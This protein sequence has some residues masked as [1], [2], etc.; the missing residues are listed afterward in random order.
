[1][2]GA[3]RRCALALGIGLAVPTV[4]HAQMSVEPDNGALSAPMGS[5][6]STTF[7]LQTDDPNR[8][9]NALEVTCDGAVVSCSSDPWVMIDA[10][11][12]VTV[13]VTYTVS[14]T[15]G[16][17]GTITVSMTDQF[18]SET[19]DGSAGVTVQSSTPHVSANPATQYTGENV[20]TN[21]PSFTLTNSGDTPATYTATVTCSG[22]S[23]CSVRAQPPS[24][25]APGA[26][27]GLIVDY[28]SY[29]ASAGNESITLH[30]TS[31]FAETASSTVTIVPLS[32]AVQVTSGTAPAAPPPTQSATYPFTIAAVGNNTSPISYTLTTSCTGAL[33]CGPAAPTSVS[34]SPGSPASATV[35]A[36]ATGNLAG[37]SGTAALTASYT[38]GW[39]HPY[40]STS[41][42]NVMVPDV[43]SYT[44]AVSPTSTTAYNE[45]NV[46]TSYSFT[47]TNSGNTQASYAVTLPT[48]SGTAS[49]CSFSSSSGG[50]TST[51]VSVNPN[52]GTASVPVYFTTLGAGQNASITLQAAG[53]SNTASGAVTVVPQSPAVTVSGGGTVSLLTNHSGTMQFTVANNGTSGTVS[54]NVTYT[55]SA[56]VTSCSAPATVSVPQGQSA[57]VTVSFQTASTT[58]TGNVNLTATAPRPPF[59]NLYQSSSAG[60]VV[61][62]SPLGVATGFMNNDDQDMSACAASC[63]AVTAAHSTAPYYTM[64][65]GRSLTLAYNS[66]RVLPQPIIY[67]DLTLPSVPA[68]LT[69]YLLQVMYHGVALPFMHTGGETTLH[70][71]S[72]WYPQGTLRLAGQVDFTSYATGMY[73]VQVIVTAQYANGT[74]DVTTVN[75]Q[76]LIVNTG[77]SSIAKGWSVAGLQRLS[78]QQEGGGYVVDEG[79]GSASY[80]AGAN[81]SAADHSVLSSIGGGWTRTYLDGSYVQYDASGLMTAAVDQLGFQT[82][83]QYDTVS[84]GV[85][86][87]YVFEPLR[88]NGY[89]ATAPYLML[90]YDANGNGLSQ[91]SEVGT[92]NPRTT[93]VIVGT[94]HLLTQITDPDNAYESYGYNGSNRLNAVTDRRGYTTTYGY[95][96]AGKLAQITAPAIPLDAGNGAATSPQNPITRVSA[97]QSVGVPLAATASAPAAVVRPD[98]VMGQLTDAASRTTKF[99]VNRW[100]APVT[101][102]DPQGQQTVVTYTGKDPVTVQYPNGSSQTYAYDSSDRL[103]MAQASGDSAT[104]Y[105]YNSASQVDSTWGKNVVATHYAYDADH[106]L[107]SVSNASGVS[108]TYAYN[109]RKQ[110]TSATDNAGHVMTYGYDAVFANPDSS[111]APGNRTTSIIMDG[112]GRAAT[113]SMP[114]VAAVTVTY[115][116]VNRARQIAQGSRPPTTVT[117]DGLVRTDVQ[118]ANGNVTHTDFNALGMPVARRDASG[119]TETFRYDIAGRMTSWTNRRGDVMTY[120]YDTQDRLTSRNGRNISDSLSYSS[121]GNIM[122]A[123][124]AVERDS[125]FH[126]PATG[127]H[128][129]A[130]S[131]VTWINGK[132]YRV[133]HGHM[134]ALGMNDSTAILVGTGS[135]PVSFRIRYTDYASATAGTNQAGLVNKIEDG[136]NTAT[137]S[138]NSEN[139]LGTL[140]N[141]TGVSVTQS[142]TALHTLDLAQYNVTALNNAF[143]RS[144]HYDDAG[145][146]DAAG[147]GGTQQIFHYDT[148]GQLASV[149]LQSVCG[150]GSAYDQTGGYVMHCDSLSST[151]TFTYDSVGNRTDFGATYLPGNRL[152]NFSGGWYAYDADGNVSQKYMVQP[153]GHNQLFYWNPENRLDS[154][155]FDGNSTVRYEYNAFGQPVKKYRNG[156]LDRVWLWD[157]DELLAEFDGSNQRVADYQ[158]AG[159]DQPYAADLGATSQTGNQYHVQDALGNVIGTYNVGTVTQTISYDPWGMPSYSGDLSSRL[160]WKGLL[161]EGGP[162]NTP[163]DVVGL[164]YMRGRWYDPQAGRFIQDDPL[165]V[166]GSLNLYGFAGDDPI[167]GSD[168][169][170]MDPTCSWVSTVAAVSADDRTLVPVVTVDCRESDGGNPNPSS[171]GN[172]TA[173]PAGPAGPSGSTTL[174][175]RPACRLTAPNGRYRVSRADARFEPSTAAAISAG[176]A[177]LNRQGIIPVI[178]SGYRSP[179]QQAA[180]VANANG[181]SILT[182][183]PVTWH[184]VGRAVDFGPNSN[185]GH[186]AAIRSAMAGAGLV[187]GGTFRHP[188]PDPRHYQSEPAGTS[189]SAAMVQACENAAGR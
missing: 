67:A 17:T 76:L 151:T 150:G 2:R 46:S 178:T 18:T 131:T 146:L 75:T 54:Y 79:G 37:G 16:A 47:L 8:A 100:G 163:S 72:D 120:G 96:G 63:F 109:T 3:L 89:S 158:Y 56:P 188:A 35:T 29:L 68:S 103:T 139:L 50:V 49:G 125:L 126:V 57:P 85:R 9:Q 20:A 34:I 51:T 92:T 23:N 179:E 141:S 142:Y 73:P 181:S 78:A 145:R 153:N 58:G 10:S 19:A 99:T 38:D 176:L 1:M 71:Q 55:C 182:P 115:D 13:T 62:S 84:S 24:G 44:V 114:T 48:C 70:F 28:Q 110:V 134:G 106:T 45:A 175:T 74:S 6:Q 133:L 88:A 140:S 128:P 174:S 87:R 77:S 152:Q 147:A 157:G 93:N 94:T 32:E 123:W 42:F 156:T 80:F 101:T 161:W 43:R 149:D 183:A 137:P 11:T 27:T 130:D 14:N 4:A 111:T 83:Y 30:V 155:T 166:D 105:H 184:S 167:N 102:T 81:A 7:T 107:L 53:P 40:S 136:F 129:G 116:A 113:T 162:N 138:Y 186:S 108:V 122:V 60:A 82:K 90:S 66:D 189:P 177:T 164:Y 104:Y 22:A 5:T 154:L 21:Y 95:D 187:W 36:A 59:V 169:S 26:S 132:R 168:P 12:P 112:Y 121:D 144:Y 160:M 33:S 15:T 65:T 69:G 64:G 61:V 39:G 41:S 170:G 52:G 172:N 173:G 165:G 127:A 97:W 124:N 159:V 25:L 135:D 98:T 86:L 143:G 118:D 171:R 185:V 91:I 148:Y 119:A 31:Q 117:F 180:L